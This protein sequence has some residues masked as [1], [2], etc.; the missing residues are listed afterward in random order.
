M[1]YSV[2]VP[3]LSLKDY[4]KNEGAAR[5]PKLSDLSMRVAEA[6]EE[7]SNFSQTAA[8]RTEES[9]LEELNQQKTVTSWT[10]LAQFLGIYR[11]DLSLGAYEMPVIAPLDKN[12][13][14]S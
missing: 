4:S 5:H 13:T 2:R 7:L 12:A 8:G 10:S 1:R 6:R 14:V 3:K 9:V 11:T